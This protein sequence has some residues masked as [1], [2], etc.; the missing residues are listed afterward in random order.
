MTRRDFEKFA[1]TIRDQ[2]E[3]NER[4][5]YT[6]PKKLLVLETLREL[7]GDQADVCESSNDMF[8]RE[9]FM[10]ACGL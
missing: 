9:R 3:K 5:D 10:K 8:D 4:A 2:V 7:A 6:R 1:V